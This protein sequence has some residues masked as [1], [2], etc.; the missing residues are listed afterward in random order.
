MISALG[1]SIFLLLA[2]LAG[3]VACTSRYT[4]RL[5]WGG[6]LCS[7]CLA[8]AV[9]FGYGG[10]YGLLMLGTFLI[11]DVAIYLYFR[12]QG[13]E[14]IKPS[15]NLRAD[16]IY[17]IFFLWLAFCALAGGGVALFTVE[18][19]LPERGDALPGMSL[20]HDRIWGPDWIL[21]LIPI[22][23]LLVVVVGGFFLVRREN[24]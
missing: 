8:L 23:T 2:A 21:V 3:L 5:L 22:L 16:R 18:P 7:V 6:A 15:R 4:E 19:G 13:L 17:R 14:S 1:I 20:L 10:Y 12:T 11:S 24:D 9:E